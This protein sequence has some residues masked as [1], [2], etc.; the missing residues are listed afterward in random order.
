MGQSRRIVLP[1]TLAATVG[2]SLMTV[3]SFAA[4][5]QDPAPA[6]EQAPG[7]E[8]A[9]K[10]AAKKAA[11]AQPGAAAPA[12]PAAPAAAPAPS[13]APGRESFATEPKTPLELWDAIDYLV[14]VG[15]ADQAVPYLQAFLRSKPDDATLLTIRE[16]YGVGSI[17]RLNDFPPTQDLAKPI[18][19]MVAT[20]SHRTATDPERIKRSLGALG[21]SREE[22]DYAVDQLRQAGPYAVPYL[23]QELGRRGLAPEERGRLAG[24]LGRLDHSA[25]PALLCVLDSPDQALAADAAEA[26][27]RIG[28]PRAVP[29]LTFYAASGGPASPLRETARRAIARLTHRP[30]EAQPRRPIR[31]LIDEARKYHLHAYRFPADK[32]EIWEW[33]GAPTPRQVSQ[34]EAEA[35]LGLRFARE[36]LALD[37]S[38]QAAQV[39]FL[40]L[41]LEKAVERV[42]LAAYPANDPTGAF[43]SALSAGP[44]VLGQV[45]RTALAD[46]HSDLAAVA[47]VALGRVTDRDA[48][49]ADQHPSPLVEAL[50]APDRRVQ[51]AAAQALVALE[52]QKPFPGSSRVVP[53]L[54]RFITNHSAPRMVVIDSNPNRGSQVAG[55]LRELGDEPLLAQTGDQGFRLAAGSADVEAVLLEPSLADGSWR[56]IDTLSNLRA[57][58]N[59]AGI[60]VFLV[61]PRGLHERLRVYTLSFPRVALMV[62]PASAPLLKQQLDAG[63]AQMGAR[64]LTPE[65]RS[66]YAQAAAALLARIAARP[67]SPFEPSLPA[68]EPAL[69]EAIG[70]P[71]AGPAA[72]A[73][74]ADVPGI[75]AQR[76]VADVLLDPSKPEAVRLNAADQLRRSIQRFGPLVSAEQERRLTEALNQTADPALHTAL[77]T[78]IGALRPKPATVGQRL[79]AIP[80]P[81]PEPSAPAPAAP[82][83][84]APAG[85]ASPA[86]PAA[87][88]PQP[89]PEIP[90]PQEGANPKP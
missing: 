83:A 30:Y 90:A 62:T 78:V 15:H 11:P 50:S 85:T 14:R 24:A 52:P 5:A 31:V 40:S 43:S 49:A 7:A 20:A 39:V 66:G 77:A 36:A 41:A 45:L 28:D 81:Q 10:K 2:L 26:L 74:L 22:Q 73:A 3:L 37:P 18:L 33:N 53:V 59:T 64:P 38:D 54:A 12:Q 76:G 82:A 27:G 87:E 4:L 1:R 60:P 9:K 17:L 47:A 55:F 44:I 79:Q 21:K 57:D 25:L 8:A 86:A 88:A 32:I 75:D 35:V 71:A 46:G 84:A 6:P 89:A 61:C 58:A 34:S 13:G 29:Y 67:G 68:A 42:G 51:F 65:E 19:D 63:L 70:S 48:L 80:P 69:T 72:L 16:R 56:L 23:V